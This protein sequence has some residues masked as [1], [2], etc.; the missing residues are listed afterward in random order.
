MPRVGG[1]THAT[2]APVRAGAP[3]RAGDT[4]PTARVRRL[5]YLRCGADL[6]PRGL[7]LEPGWCEWP[8]CTQPRDD[9]HHRLG[10]KDGGRHGDRADQLNQ[11]AWL[12]AACRAHHNQVTSPSGAQLVEA[13]R[14]G[15]VLREHQDALLVPVL[16]RHHPRPVLLDNAGDWS[17]RPEARPG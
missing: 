9:L 16:T 17:P 10:R 13:R 2:T 6:G 4:G 1:R 12:L 14:M 11:P 15:W 5:V 7:V 8:G 3:A